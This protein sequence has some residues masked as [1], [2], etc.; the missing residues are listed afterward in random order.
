MIQWGIDKSSN[1]KMQF[2][3]CFMDILLVQASLNDEESFNEYKKLVE[4]GVEYSRLFPGHLY[5]KL[6]KGIRQMNWDDFNY[7]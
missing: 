1:I 5:D 3:E 6:I 2:R 4:F 7:D